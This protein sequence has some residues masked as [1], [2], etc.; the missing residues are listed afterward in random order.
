MFVLLTLIVVG[1]VVVRQLTRSI[2]EVTTTEEKALQI[3]DYPVPIGRILVL[4]DTST[5]HNEEMRLLASNS[6]SQLGV[7]GWD[8]FVDSDKEARVRSW[9]PA[10]LNTSGVDLTKL[11]N[12]NLAGIL[13]ITD[14][15]E[16]V[17][18]MCLIDQNGVH[19][20]Q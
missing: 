15:I 4:N 16:N 7:I 12:E 3:Q 5:L 8:I 2:P 9:L 18:S 13:L 6:I 19:T 14:G 17:P 1:A 20:L 10:D 11:E